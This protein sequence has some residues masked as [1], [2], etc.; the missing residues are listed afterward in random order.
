MNNFP[1]VIDKMTELGLRQVVLRQHPS[2]WLPLSG[3]CCREIIWQSVWDIVWFALPF[4]PNLSEPSNRLILMFSVE[5][6]GNSWRKAV[7]DCSCLLYFKEE[8]SKG[9]LSESGMVH[10]DWNAALPSLPRIFLPVRTPKSPQTFPPSWKKVQKTCCQGRRPFV[11]SCRHM[12][13]LLTRKEQS[14]R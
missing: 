4:T 13:S 11:F 10:L 3:P 1:K 14:P 9:S 5:W 2:F 6:R 8:G 7:D 12:V